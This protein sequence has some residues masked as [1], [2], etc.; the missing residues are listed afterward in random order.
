[1]R[2]LFLLIAVFIGLLLTTTHGAFAAEQYMPATEIAMSGTSIDPQFPIRFDVLSDL[3][4]AGKADF[5]PRLNTSSMTFSGA[6]YITGIGWVLLSTSDGVYQVRLNCGSQS[7]DALTSSCQ[8][9]GT[10]H[11]ENIGDIPMAGVSYDPATGKLQWKATTNIGEINFS[12]ISLPLRKV[13]LTSNTIIADHSAIINIAENV[14]YTTKAGIWSLLIR[15]LNDTT[16]RSFTS[17]DGVFSIDLSLASP[18]ILEI[19]DPNGSTTKGI[20]LIVNPAELSTTLVGG[21]YF[22]S[23]YCSAQPAKCPD[24][25]TLSSTKLQQEIIGAG[26]P[27]ANGIDGYKYTLTPRDKYGN[28][29]TT[30]GIRIRY[31]ATVKNAQVTVDENSNYFVGSTEGDAFMSLGLYLADSAG[32]SITPIA[33]DGTD[34]IYTIRSTAPTSITETIRLAWIGYSISTTEPYTTVIPTGSYLEFKPPYLVSLSPNGPIYVNYPHTFSGAFGYMDPSLTSITPDIIV[35]LGLS[36]TAGAEW[37]WLSSD[38]D[39]QCTKNPTGTSTNTLCDWWEPPGYLMSTIALRTASDFKVSGTYTSLLD[40]DPEKTRLQLYTHYQLGGKDIIYPI[41]TAELPLA[42]KVVS[43]VKILGQSS[44]DNIYTTGDRNKVINEIRE[45]TMIAS[46]NRT[47]YTDGDFL[48][49]VGDGSTPYTIDAHTLWPPM[50]G[51]GKAKRTIV[52]IGSD[53]QIT[54][55]IAKWTSPYALIALTDSQGRGGNITIW[56]HVTDITSTLIAEHGIVSETSEYQLTIE[57]SMV[58]A[59]PARDIPPLTCPYYIETC[60]SPLPYDL[61]GKRMGFIGL[62]VADRPSKV[63]TLHPESAPYEKIPVVIMGDT[64][65]ISDPPPLLLK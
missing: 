1:M 38:T 57:G 4:N 5:W 39:T 20:N 34:I 61:P 23:N 55:N 60:P 53:I 56:A 19:T 59:N 37:K 12:G 3:T 13:W 24:G 30:G 9:E 40:A 11:S 46:R 52:I 26:T 63:S 64:R 16:S 48:I 7:I 17:P 44:Q 35:R 33:L 10:A 14:S 6:F 47:D 32:S 43:R 49:I 50:T 21:T 29:V 41:P 54:E 15:P 22:I 8:L 36:T 2:R 25:V 65:L 45:R 42:E 51:I 27:I 62:S 58:S 18:Y 31:D 28:R